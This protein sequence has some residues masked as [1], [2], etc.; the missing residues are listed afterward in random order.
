MATQLLN[1]ELIEIPPELEEA[2][3]VAA[4]PPSLDPADTTFQEEPLWQSLTA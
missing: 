1:G 2:F 4:P 3:L